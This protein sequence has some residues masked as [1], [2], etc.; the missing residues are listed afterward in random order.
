ML[1]PVQ[2]ELIKEHCFII[3]P[4][5]GVLVQRKPSDFSG[6]QKSVIRSNN[7]SYEWGTDDKIRV[8]VEVMFPVIIFGP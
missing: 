7:V 4:S 1:S 2:L 5:I 6:A 8:T 3:S